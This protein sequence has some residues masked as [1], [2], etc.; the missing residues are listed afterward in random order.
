MQYAFVAIFNTT[1]H[2]ILYPS[3]PRGI[4][5]LSDVCSSIHLSICLH[6]RKLTFALKF[7]VKVLEILYYLNPLLDWVCIWHEDK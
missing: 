6:V 1:E 4:K 5:R 7:C 3:M 2:V